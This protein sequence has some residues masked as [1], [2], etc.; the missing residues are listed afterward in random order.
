[1]ERLGSRLKT[2]AA[3]LN[4]FVR[5]S[6]NGEGRQTARGIDFDFDD[7]TVK[8]NHRRGVHLGKHGFSLSYAV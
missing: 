3:F 2:L 1:M 4:D 6:N 8:P 5:G 7:L